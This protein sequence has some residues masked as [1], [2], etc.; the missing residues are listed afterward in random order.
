MR[1]FKCLKDVPAGTEVCPHC[2]QALVP[3]TE[4]QRKSGENDPPSQ[5]PSRIREYQIGDTIKSRYEVREILDRKGTGYT[6]KVRDREK[7][8]VFILKEIKP[9]LFV[10][11]SARER[12]FDTV[13]TIKE[14][15]IPE[16]IAIHDYGEDDGVVYIVSEYIEGLTLRKLLDV[17]KDMKQ[18]F[19]GEELE[20][21]LTHLCKALVEVHNNGIAHGDLKPENI[22][23]LP[24]GIK[25]AELGV[26][27]TL[28]PLDFIS[29]Q[30]DLGD[31][32]KY[33]APEV[34]IGGALSK[35]SD[36]YSLGVI[37][38]EMLTG[39][40]A[41]SVAAPPS[42]HNSD[43][44]EG[45]NEVLLK[46]LRQD[47]EQRTQYVSLFYQELLTV[48]GQKARIL[49]EKAWIQKAAAT[50][51]QSGTLKTEIDEELAMYVETGQQT[52]TEQPPQ[53][54]DAKKK[55]VDETRGAAP[56]KQKAP[57]VV[58][59]KQKVH[60]PKP[61]DAAGQ[62]E[63]KAAQ[64]GT[65][66]SRGDGGIDELAKNLET[67]T[68]EIQ[69]RKAQTIMG[70][71]APPDR[72]PI[73][74]QKT[75]EKTLM[76]MI[77]I[78]LSVALIGVIALLWVV[79]R[80]NNRQVQIAGIT[81]VSTQQ[82]K[83]PAVLPPPLP[84]APQKPAAPPPAAPQIKPPAEAPP[85]PYPKIRKR[86][87]VPRV[88]RKVAMVTPLPPPPKCPDDM[89]LVPGGYFVMGS[90]LSDPLRDFSEKPN[91]RMYVKSFCIDKYEYPDRKGMIP[92]SSVSFYTA[93]Q[94]CSDEGR[95]LCTEKEWEK[96]CKGPSGLKYPY[97]NVWDPSK[98]NTQDKSGANRSIAP[99]G[100]FPACVSGYGA[101]DM[102]GNVMEWTSS[103]FSAQ[104][105]A[106]RVLKGG[107]F[108]KP[109]WAS[110]CAYRYNMLPTSSAYIEIGFRCCKGA[111]R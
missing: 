81:A 70:Q 92:K 49:D 76:T 102:S 22:F 86:I 69:D 91:V 21:I 67:V 106:D 53:A 56:A 66:D 68:H 96:A 93:S 14:M 62:Q 31:P 29:I 72:P 103:V 55:P 88:K 20:S 39:I 57:S 95:R 9:S 50:T 87:Y 4:K 65:E 1:C 24:S 84:I 13:K 59:G 41:G 63:T 83:R 82:K 111:A 38:Y 74:E 27:A 99:S 32:Y 2:G 73:V 109:D 79:L 46:A 33:I 71:V 52:A 45:T 54:Q 107:S 100:S 108:A 23:I 85:A 44:P 16:I 35:V 105:T 101:Y 42:T 26:T 19:K 58:Q 5:S 40:I 78:V 60:V 37:V 12:F 34:I 75:K 94:L 89:V 17:R 104:D 36:I 47:H 28:S 7:K 98:C 3:K 11:E 25:I 97:G 90:S 110:R 80:S 30:Q 77:V 15:N 48:F 43:L 18:F 10:S 8:K 51:E 61:V 6:Y 64:A